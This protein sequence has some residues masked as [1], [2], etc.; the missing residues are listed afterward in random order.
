M[1]TRRQALRRLT[2]KWLSEVIRDPN[3]A[4]R[5][6]LR[7]LLSEDNIRAVVALDLYA[8][9]EDFEDRRRG[10]EMIRKWFLPRQPGVLAQ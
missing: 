9:F 10:R 1:C 6:P 2:G 8:D 7:L 3:T 4:Y 5:L